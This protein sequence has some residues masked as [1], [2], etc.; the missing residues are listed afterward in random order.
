[1]RIANCT[2]HLNMLLSFSR[3]AL[4]CTELLFA[5]QIMTSWSHMSGLSV[6]Q[7]SFPNT[8]GLTRKSHW[9]ATVCGLTAHFLHWRLW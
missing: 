1:M 2:F 8:G 7:Q 6:R 3:Q 9:D 5:V 4:L